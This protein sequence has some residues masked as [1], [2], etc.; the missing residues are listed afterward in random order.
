MKLT[1]YIA[2]AL[3]AVAATACSDSGYWEESLP[4]GDVYAFPKAK[5]S[6]AL[7]ATD[8][9]PTSYGVE[10]LRNHA[11]QAATIAVNP[12]FSSPVLS[13]PDSVTFEAGQTSAIYTVTI[14]ATKGWE[15]G[16]TYTVT[17][18]L[19]EKNYT[20][21]QADNASFTLSMVQDYTWLEAGNAMVQSNWVDE[22][23]GKY[24]VAVERA[25]EYNANGNILY[26]L[27]SPFFIMEPDYAEEGAHLQFILNA[28][29]DPV[30]VTPIFQYIGES[31]DDYGNFYFAMMQS[32]AYAGSFTKEGTVYTMDG[33][34]TCD[35]G[36]NGASQKP[37]DYETIK[38]D[39]TPVK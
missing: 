19:D 27:V 4:Q 31:D 14:D 8:A 15:I 12:E 2:I 38:F 29:N 7:G 3:A 34:I 17:L 35:E 5:A 20:K 36:T 30:W 32:G 23:S 11:G 13:G 39:Y 28:N 24:K 22:L 25:K 21:P 18:A 26:R 10:V 37:L 1:S 16:S 33:L 6:I 9:V